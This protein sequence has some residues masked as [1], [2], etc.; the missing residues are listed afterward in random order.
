[1]L[2]W[3]LSKRFRSL[4]L[5]MFTNPQITK[6]TLFHE[7]N[8]SVDVEAAHKNE[9]SQEEESVKTDKMSK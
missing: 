5:K 2:L 9:R 6:I 7:L 8:I 1:M 4:Y 3:P